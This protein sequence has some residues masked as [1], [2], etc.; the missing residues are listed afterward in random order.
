ML[1]PLL[2]IVFFAIIG[3]IMYLN[4]PARSTGHSCNE[5]GAP[6]SQCRCHKKQCDRCGMPKPQ[7]GCPKKE[8]CQFC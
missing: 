5:C 4:W 6:P 8:G 2:I 1:L 7:C 3:Y